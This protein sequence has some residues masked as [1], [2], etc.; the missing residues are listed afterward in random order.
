[1]IEDKKMIEPLISNLLTPRS[2]RVEKAQPTFYRIVLEPFERGYAYTLGHALRRILLSSMPGAAIVEVKIENV[3]HEYSTLPGVREDVL[4]ILL[5]LKNVAVKM[6]GS[7]DKITLSLNK[8]GEGIVRAGDISTDN[9]VKIINPDYIIA[10]LASEGKLNMELTV[11]KGLGYQPAELREHPEESSRM[12][13]VLKLDSSFSP[14]RKVAYQVENARV[15]KRADLDKLIL[16]IETNGTLTPEE[17]IRQAA[18]ILQNQLQA[19]VDLKSTEMSASAG[20]KTPS[21]LSPLLYQ[22]VDDLELTVRSTNCLK[23][24]NIYYVGDLVQHTEIELLQT[25]N[26]GRKSL[27]EIKELLYARGLSLGMSLE[28]WPP[29]DLVR[30]TIKTT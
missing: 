10:H 23:A 8:K 17:A 13:G 29:E 14:V 30:N 12:V 1:M 9:R 28:N 2:I 18:M 26:L 5:N 24:Q 20:K 7:I 11:A 4:N 15:E 3:L 21:G 22:P 6:D 27:S 25:P 19:F 16:E